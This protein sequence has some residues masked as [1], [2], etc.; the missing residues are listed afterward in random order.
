MDENYSLDSTAVLPLAA[1]LDRARRKR[2]EKVALAA[3]SDFV[4][5]IRAMTSIILVHT[6]VPRPEEHYTALPAE[7]GQ[8]VSY[9]RRVVVEGDCQKALHMAG[10]YL[11]EGEAV[12]NTHEAPETKKPVIA[13][14]AQRITEA[15]EAR[16]QAE[17]GAKDEIFMSR[18]AAES[19]KKSKLKT[20][21][22][23]EK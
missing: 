15:M 14:A 7:E 21:G 8:P 13:M 17:A 11:R 6:F 19:L 16:V 10:D 4:L 20:E 23:V 2:K 22:G 5:L 12:S 3:T 1:R 18:R 9:V